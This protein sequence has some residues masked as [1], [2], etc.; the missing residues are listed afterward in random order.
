[1]KNLSTTVAVYS[2]TTAAEQ[3]WLNIESAAEGGAIDLADGAL[4]TVDQDGVTT[5]E[6]QSHHGWGKGAVAGA[7]VGVLFPPAAIGAA[8]AGATG[9]GI[10]AR[11]NRSLDK[12]DIEA[13]GN[14][15]KDGEIAMVV[16]SSQDT[17]GATEKL[18]KGAT[19]SLTKS[20]STAEDIRAAM[21]DDTGGAASG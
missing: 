15:M 18:L 13:L 14:V 19:K 2:D 1:M 9:G 11:M 10:A 16:L 6:R 8:V 17:A 5:L 4:V 20:S 12:G 7:V 21:S 3:D